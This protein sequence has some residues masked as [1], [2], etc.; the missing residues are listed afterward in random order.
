MMKIVYAGAPEF[1]VAPLKSLSEAGF[2]VIAVVTQPDKPVGRKAVLTPTPLKSYALSQGIPAYDFAKIREH[3]AELRALGADVMITCAY[4]QLLTQEVL[5]AFP[6]GVYNIHASLLPR[7]RGASP[8]QHAILAGDTQTGVTVMKTDIGL[9][10]GD[11]LLCEKTPVLPDDTAGTLSEK[12]SSLGGECIVRAMKELE[13][14]AAAFAKQDGA[15]ATVCKKI[16][17]EDCLTDFARPAEEVC[18][19]IR[20]MN[21]SPLAYAFLKGKLVNFYFAEPCGAQAD[22]AAA[23]GE[24]VRADKTGVYVAAGGGC[25]KITE[26]QLEGGKRMRAADAVNGRKI[27]AGDIFAKERA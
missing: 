21:P 23:P 22:A 3:A 16:G 27:A 1:S 10:T 7:W 18:R 2:R 20:A 19:L 15:R 11:M 12:L 14:G 8:I 25:V 26:L 24:V 5:D 4:G 17:K 6:A 13:A 9:D